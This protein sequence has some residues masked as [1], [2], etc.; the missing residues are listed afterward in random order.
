LGISR[1]AR[2]D[3]RR[4]GAVLQNEQCFHCLLLT[5]THCFRLQ[6]YM[7]LRRLT[8]P[9]NEVCYFAGPVK[10]SIGVIVIISRPSYLPVN[11]RW[12]VI[13]GCCAASR[14]WYGL[15]QHVPAAPSINCVS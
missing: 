6:M 1:D 7:G 10:P 11:R 14:T 12:S 13:P 9:M 2:E 15:P 8:L 5:Q 3:S 4:K